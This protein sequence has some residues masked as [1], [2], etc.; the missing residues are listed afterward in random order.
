MLSKLKQPLEMPPSMVVV[1]VIGLSVFIIAPAL[2][3]GPLGTV[4]LGAVA[5]FL[6]FAMGRRVKESQTRRRAE[7]AEGKIHPVSPY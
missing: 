1:L 5:T 2:H 6:A 3:Y 7:A 4:V